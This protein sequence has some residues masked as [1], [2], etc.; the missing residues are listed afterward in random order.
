[1]NFR[2]SIVCVALCAAALAV[3]C[4]TDAAEP[5]ASAYP[6][7][8]VRMVIPFAPGGATDIIGRLVAQK[9]GETLKQPVVLE[10]V[11][12]AASMLGAERVA[13]APNDGYTLLVATSATLAT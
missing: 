6:S 9:M 5:A 1:M 12:G 13:R 4:R 11:A 2:S 3:A 7:K 10:N 8:P